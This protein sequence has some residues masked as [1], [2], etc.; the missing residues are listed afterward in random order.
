MTTVTIITE[1]TSDGSQHVT[2]VS[3]WTNGRQPLQVPKRPDL[4]TERGVL[5]YCL[6]LENNG[7]A[8][9]ADEILDDYCFA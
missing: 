8:D 2:G 3:S 4:Y 7:R 6:W 5:A 9:E 1:S